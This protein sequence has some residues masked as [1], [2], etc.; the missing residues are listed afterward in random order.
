M[1][2][3]PRLVSNVIKSKIVKYHGVPIIIL[4]FFRDMSGNII[5]HFCEILIKCIQL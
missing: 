1:P 2:P 4:Q 5:V 3:W